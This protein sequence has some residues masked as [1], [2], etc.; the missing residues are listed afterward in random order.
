MKNIEFINAGAGS[1]KTYTLTEK[2]AD[3]IRTRATSPS[4]IILTTF[5][6]MAAE[7]FRVKAR[8]KLL[9]KGCHDEAAMMDSATVGTVHAVALGYIKRYWYLLG[10]GANVDVL[11]EEDEARY[12]SETLWHVAGEADIAVLNRY[13]ELSGF[14]QYMSSKI[15]YSYWQADINDLVKKA[16]TFGI[17]D[18]GPSLK[19]SLELFD[20]IFADEPDCEL[21]ATR[22]KVVETMFRV[23][24]QWRTEFTAYKKEH[25][26]IS[27]NDMERLFLELLDNPQVQDDIRQGV[28]YVFVDE[29]QDSNPTQVRI[30]S[31]L[32]DLAAKG[33]FWVGDPKQAIYDFRGCDTALTTAISQYIADRADAGDPGFANSTL[34]DSWRSDPALVDLANKVF[35]PVFKGVLP[36]KKVELK[37]ARKDLLPKETP[38]IIHWNT[39]PGVTATGKPSLNAGVVS[40]T[41]AQGVYKLVTGQGLVTEVVDKETRKTR[42]IR[43]EDVAVL[44]R[45]GVE[46]DDIAGR[47]RR[48]GLE[49]ATDIA[50]D[51]T[52]VEVAFLCAVL[53]YIIG[54]T[55]LLEAELASMYGLLTTKDII[56]HPNEV[57]TRGLFPLL[58]TLREEFADKPVSR[59]VSGVIDRLD[60]EH[61]AS[62]W[63]GDSE[64]RNTIEAVRALAASYEGT[65]L[66]RGEAATLSGFLGTLTVSGLNVE[67]KIQKG[68]VNVMTYHKSKGLEWNIVVLSSLDTDDLE[69]KTPLKPKLDNKKFIK[70]HY[71]GAVRRRLSSPTPENPYSDFVVRY[72][73]KIASGNA[74]IPTTV[75]QRILSRS[76]FREMMEET[77]S[78]L[79]RLLYVGVTRARDVLISYSP[80][81]DS[82]GWLINLG[83]S[84]PGCADL[85]GGMGAI[86]GAGCPKALV[87]KLDRDE[88]DPEHSV[89]EDSRL[90]MPGTRTERA[91]KYLSPSG[92]EECPWEAS[93]ERVFPESGT[94]QAITVT[95][96]VTEPERFGT[97]IHNVFA[98][99][100]EGDAAWNAE[101]ARRTVDA[102]GFSSL[103]ANPGEI[104]RASDNLF[105]YLT[106]TFGKAV[107]VHHE[108]PFSYAD[109]EKVVTGEMDLVWETADGCV[110]VDFKNHVSDDGTA[111]V[112][113]AP[114][115]APQM[116]CYDKA[117]GMA[118]KRTRAILIFYALQ[119]EIIKVTFK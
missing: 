100:R 3:L 60:L 15:D 35:V 84:S 43:P 76:D 2:M 111:P 99:Y 11:P 74:N 112:D 39:I 98:A 70:R 53:N 105:A 36:A 47:L 21:K 7:E 116:A 44:C 106:K 55:N 92:V 8:A 25:N 75:K 24:G 77:R 41:I 22:R 50:R 82:M 104:V 51:T 61:L 72:I 93:F 20:D 96:K 108:L 102:Y 109:G 103:L 91:P 81:T 95:G 85:N 73:P 46:V 86:W 28:D 37:A 57:R 23:A 97:C 78:E 89:I 49:V 1:G 67:R 4:R 5:T 40:E 10:L 52:N 114:K 113:H 32:S 6:R 65:C 18:L 31:K 34:D 107:A 80:D 59:V 79:A 56:E 63:E 90:F 17:E 62:R 33:S 42:P 38:R 19:A 118:G 119:G 27:H 68:G 87:V 14:K 69:N 88:E 71:F 30:F 83:I 16:E 12:I 48:M 9:E 64:T 110:L 58:D 29:F 26:L 45:D 13:A 101:V 66:A 117:L 54:S 94:P 115:Y